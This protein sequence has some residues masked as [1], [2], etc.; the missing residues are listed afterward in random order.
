M[1]VL[2]AYWLFVRLELVWAYRNYTPRQPISGQHKPE[3]WA[4]RKPESFY[5]CRRVAMDKVESE[6]E[7]RHFRKGEYMNTQEE[8]KARFTEIMAS[9]ELLGD[10]DSDNYDPRLP[11][12][13]L[14]L[15]DA[16]MK[17][18]L[19]SQISKIDDEA[20]V[21]NMINALANTGFSALQNRVRNEEQPSED[22][23]GCATMAVHVAWVVGAFT[24]M[25]LMLGTYAKFLMELD[26]EAPDELLLILRP[27]NPI[28]EG[29]GGQDPIA[30]L[31]DNFLES[32]LKD[33]IKGAK[34]PKKGK[35]E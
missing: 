8:R 7:L 35:G 16:Q 12:G 9:V 29:A 5:Q 13:T 33:I 34:N 28:L 14:G 1:F 21:G 20:F 17:M 10:P 11:N 15:G 25:A 23:L 6:V 31:G 18:A 2:A 19:L 27:N 30:L 3:R 24:P 22:D 4:C 26:V 32:V